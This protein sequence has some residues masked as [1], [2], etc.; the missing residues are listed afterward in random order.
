MLAQHDELVDVDQ[1]EPASSTIVRCVGRQDLGQVEVEEVIRAVADQRLS[2]L[3]A[4]HLRNLATCV[5]QIE[6]D[7]V[8]GVV[9]EA[10]TAQGGSAIVLAAAKSPDRPIKVYDVFDTIPAPSAKDGA[11]VHERY[12]VIAQGSATGLRGDTHYGYRPELYDEVRGS[13]ERLGVPVEQHSVEL[14]KGLFQDTIELDGPVAFAHLDGDWY[15][16]TMVC[17]ERIAPKLSPGGRMI[18]DDYYS[19]S[20]CHRAVNDY[21]KGRSDYRLLERAKLHVVRSDERGSE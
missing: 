17:L 12:A 5:R 11:D 20:G 15:E 4:G 13:F 6:A 18:I 16:S 7:G 19:W 8:P 14:V 3:S 9:V 21:F 1:R 2:Y 10:G